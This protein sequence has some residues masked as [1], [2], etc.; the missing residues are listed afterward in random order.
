MEKSKCKLIQDL[1]EKSDQSRPANNSDLIKSDYDAFSDCENTSMLYSTNNSTDD[2]L[3][4][5][6]CDAFSDCGNTSIL[7][8]TNNN[9][10]DDLIK[11]DY[12]AFSD[13]G[14]HQY[15]AQQT[16][17]VMTKVPLTKALTAAA[18]QLR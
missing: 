5:S 4:K 16:T 10:D 15:C 9:S 1:D 11:S 14:T 2:D 13:C 12:D 8:P 3:I 7:C 17:V 18:A 6:D